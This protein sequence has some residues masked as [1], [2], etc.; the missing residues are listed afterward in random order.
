MFGVMSYACTSSAGS[1]AFGSQLRRNKL[2]YLSKNTGGFGILFPSDL[3]K[4]SFGI[5]K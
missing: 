5:S 2:N 1:K 3:K 4:P